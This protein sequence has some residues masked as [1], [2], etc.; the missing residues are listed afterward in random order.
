MARRNSPLKVCTST[1]RTSPSGPGIVFFIR[2]NFHCNGLWSSFNMTRSHSFRL[3][4]GF[5]HFCLCYSCCR[6]SRL[7]RSQN[8]DLRCWTW[9]HLEDKLTA[10]S[11]SVKDSNDDP[12]K[13][14]PCV[15]GCRS[16]GSTDK[17]LSG[18]E[19]NIASIS[20]T[21]VQSSSKSRILVL[22]TFTK[23]FFIDFIFASQRPPKLGAAG[24]YQFE[25]GIMDTRNTENASLRPFSALLTHRAQ[26]QDGGFD[27]KKVPAQRRPAEEVSDPAPLPLP[28]RPRPSGPTP[29]PPPPPEPPRDPPAFPQDPLELPRRPTLRW[30][31][32]RPRPRGRS[33]VVPRLSFTG[34][35][36]TDAGIDARI[37]QRL[38]RMATLQRLDRLFKK[39]KYFCAHCK[40]PRTVFDRAM[41]ELLREGSLYQLGINPDAVLAE[42]SVHEFFLVRLFVLAQNAACANKRKMIQVRDLVWASRL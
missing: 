3:G 5:F 1:T 22:V 28:K 30:R 12:T 15:R 35:P 42:D 10:V 36:D 37:Q 23:I 25:I 31:R 6:Y 21:N 11:F 14:C 13:N 33:P 32:P 29:P 41:K 8:L 27:Y 40:V 19:F 24:K 2:A 18:L 39:V 34:P 20:T 16:V 9:L 38:D 26:T 17:G 7:Q 4:C